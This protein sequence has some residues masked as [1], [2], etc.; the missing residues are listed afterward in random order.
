[1]TDDG[2]H[3]TQADG[4]AEL[5]LS[6][7]ATLNAMTPAFW[8]RLP[9]IV[10]ALDATGRTRAMIIA[11]TGP[12]FCAGMDV[13]VFAD[14]GAATASARGRERMR[15][16]GTLLQEALNRLERARFPVIAAIQGGCIGG[17]L[18]LACVCDIRYATSDAFFCIQEVN[19]GMMADLGTL[20]RMPKLI[21]AGIVRELAYTGDRWSAADAH[22]LGFVNRTFDSTDALLAGTRACARRIASRSALAVAGS[23]EAINFARDYPVDVASRMAINWQAGMLDVEDLRSG[24][25]AMRTR[26]TAPSDPLYPLPDA[27]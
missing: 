21:P 13:S 14:A 5:T 17:G 15:N 1:M 10:D 20:Q 19:I 18:D 16:V 6:S 22:R 23:K 24:V 12:H 25:E 4:I 3:L 26:K 27:L 7:P 9:R 11:S 2:L 8:N